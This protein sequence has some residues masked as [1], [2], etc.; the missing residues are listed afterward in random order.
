I[1]K[2]L[3]QCHHTGTKGSRFRARGQEANRYRPKF[4]R[5]VGLL[6]RRGRKV[7]FSSRIFFTH[8]PLISRAGT[9][10]FSLSVIRLSGTPGA[11]SITPWLG[12]AAGPRRCGRRGLGEAWGRL[13]SLYI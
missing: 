7:I 6:R 13:Y 12:P 1:G 2:K 8:A 9:A 3:G 5:F 4:F 11:S 10:T